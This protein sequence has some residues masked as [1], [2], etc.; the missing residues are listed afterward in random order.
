MASSL[1]SPAAVNVQH[2]PNS[3][4][5][6]AAVP[7]L[8]SIRFFSYS[9]CSG[10]KIVSSQPSSLHPPRSS[11]LWLRRCGASSPHP[12][13]PPE[14]GPPPGE[15]DDSNSGSLVS[16]SRFQENVQ[17]FFAVLFWMSLFFWSSAWDGRNNGR[18][19]KGPK[20]WK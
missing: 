7:L 13:S 3:S 16:F 6:T 8:P 17:I 20:F 18:S 2:H 14:S 19:D 12:P 10:S 4:I 15:D 5:F 11:N 1:L 9:H